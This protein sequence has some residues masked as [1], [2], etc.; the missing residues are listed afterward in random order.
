MDRK[1]YRLGLNLKTLGVTFL[2]ALLVVGATALTSRAFERL[3]AM[4]EQLATVQMESLMN[5]VRIAQQAESLITLVMMLSIAETQNDRR[6]A[7]VELNDRSH[8][9]GQMLDELSAQLVDESML[10]RIQRL[11][12]ELD[13]NNQHLDALVRERLRQPFEADQALHLS[14]VT[15][16]SQD[17]AGEMVVLTG[18][19]AAQVRLQISHQSGAL[20]TEI[21][22]HQQN[23]I[24]LAVFIVVFALLA[25]IY[26]D[27]TVVRRILRMKHAVER[28]EISVNDFERHGYDEIARLSKTVVSFIERIQQQEAYMKK[29]NVELSFLAERDALTGLANRRHFQIAA[30]HLLRQTHLNVCVALCDIDFFKEVN[31]KR[32]HLAGDEALK[33][34]ANLLTCGL[35]ESDII[36]R[37]GGEE[38]AILFVVQSATEA[39]SVIDKLRLQIASTPLSIENQPELGLTCSFGLS[40]IEDLPLPPDVSDEHLESILNQA[41]IAA[42]KVLYDAKYLGRNRV[43]IVADPVSAKG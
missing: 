20:Q 37:F 5:S 29:V 19:L 12:L 38:F 26:F 7:I 35:R 36:A 23:L 43:C 15:Q 10:N 31:D 6:T 3:H 28:P 9:I 14:Q 18:H 11:H 2:I 39:F 33:A 41:L 8:W 17:L 32:G 27:V 42:D 25:G 34:L 16:H 22:K 1:G 40:L 4:V 21:K 30:K 24:V 13:S